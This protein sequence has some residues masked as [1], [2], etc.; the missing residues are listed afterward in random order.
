MKILVS[1]NT[2]QFFGDQIKQIDSSV[3]LIA[4]DPN[5]CESPRMEKYR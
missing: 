1:N 4:I 3:E 5:D 2:K